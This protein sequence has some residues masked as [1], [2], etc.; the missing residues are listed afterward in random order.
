MGANSCLG[1][2]FKTASS[3]VSGSCHLHSVVLHGALLPW[4]LDEEHLAASSQGPSVALCSRSRCAD[5]QCPCADG[6]AIPQ[7]PGDM[8]SCDLYLEDLQC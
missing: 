8:S 4:E 3:P 2:G 6:R 1:S 7:P 5:G